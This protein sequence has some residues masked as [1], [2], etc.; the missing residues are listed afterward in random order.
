MTSLLSLVLTFTT[1]NNTGAQLFL[2]VIGEQ[3]IHSSLN[4]IQNS[5]TNTYLKSRVTIWR[6]MWNNNTSKN[7]LLFRERLLGYL[8]RPAD[9]G[10]KRPVIVWKDYAKRKCRSENPAKNPDCGK[11]VN[12]GEDSVRKPQQWDNL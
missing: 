4:R 5:G 9:W 1:N 7:D 12:V 10:K 2:M 6:H 11:V 8:W 3:L